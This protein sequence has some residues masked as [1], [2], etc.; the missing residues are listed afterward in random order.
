MIDLAARG[1]RGEH[2]KG[3][4]HVGKFV[5]CVLVVFPET[6]IGEVGLNFYSGFLC[7]HSTRIL[8]GKNGDLPLPTEK[9]NSTADARDLTDQ[10]T[11]MFVNT[12]DLRLM[13]FDQSNLIMLPC[14][15]RET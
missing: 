2:G 10:L 9:Q 11:N 3:E 7:V 4:G 15:F 13:R 12:M 8:L 5:A 1:A 14:L 6:H